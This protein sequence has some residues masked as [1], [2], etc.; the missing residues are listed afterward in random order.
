M[1]LQAIIIRADGAFA[2]TEEL[3]RQSFV[4]AFN[5]AGFT[6]DVDR[7]QFASSRRIGPLRARMAHFVHQ[8]LKRGQV[9]PDVDALVS[10]MNRR[11]A[12]VF[13]QLIAEGAVAPRNGVRELI[14]T[15]RQEGVRLALAGALTREEVD[16][17]LI[18][19]LGHRG[20]E[21][22]DVIS[23]VDEAEGASNAKA[24]YEK[25]LTDIKVDAAQCL[26]V[27]ATLSGAN[28]AKAAG[29]RAITTRSTFC[30]ESPGAGDSAGC[31][32]DIPSILERSGNRRSEPLS[33][34]E[35]ADL[36][37][38]LQQLHAG[39]YSTDK[40]SNGGAAMRVSD[41]LKAKGSA[42]KTIESTATLRA[43]AQGLKIEGVGAMVVKDAKDAVQGIISE[44]DLA[45]GL[46]EFG[47][48]LSSMPV[49]ALMTKAVITCAPEDSVVAVA[50]VMTQRRIRHLPVVV[51]GKL[52]GLVSIGDVIK[53]RLDE[54]QLEA[55][56]LRDFALS[57]K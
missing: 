1:T 15:A 50:K 17:L 18:H 21:T 49:S 36:F 51:D 24:L 10:A 38:A 55:N 9:V 19:A 53:H 52:A 27:E 7:E 40:D 32:A 26:V 37:A 35:R 12:K 11:A 14:V 39:N 34:A 54:V 25:V 5:E 28:A 30:L 2:E 13:C 56:V 33:A 48:E 45:R 47:G 41:I 42:V 22:F 46:A 23:L 8:Y 43:L 29:L 4:A 3:R 16:R 31:F 6:W 20:P 44:R 57:R